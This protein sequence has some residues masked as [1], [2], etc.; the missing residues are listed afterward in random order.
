MEALIRSKWVALGSST[1]GCEHKA[2]K[3]TAHISFCCG[4]LCVWQRNSLHEDQQLQWATIITMWRLTMCVRLCPGLIPL[5]LAGVVARHLWCD[6][7]ER[8]SLIQAASTWSGQLSRYISRLP[9]RPLNVDGSK[10][11]LTTS[12]GHIG[13]F[14]FVYGTYLMWYFHSNFVIFWCTLLNESHLISAVDVLFL[15]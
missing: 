8:T 15:A 14:F 13:V 3:F 10:F 2:H 9:S 6:A 11:R 7:T 12:P 1:A 5:S 4:H